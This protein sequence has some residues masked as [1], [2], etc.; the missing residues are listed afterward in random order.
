ML[1]NFSKFV[2]NHQEDIILLIGIIFISLF[3]FAVGYITATYQEEQL[4]KIEKI[5]A[6]YNE[7]LEQTG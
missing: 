2:K 1:S 7:N 6:Y 4:L 3:S 5:E